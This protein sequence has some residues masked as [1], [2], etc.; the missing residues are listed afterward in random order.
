MKAAEDDTMLKRCRQ[1]ERRLEEVT[2][3]CAHMIKRKD[4]ELGEKNSIIQ[5]LQRKLADDSKRFQDFADVW[6]SRVQVKEKG[7]NKAIAEL[8]FAEGQIVEERKRTQIQIEK[9]K[10]RDRDIARLK[11]EHSE[12]LRVR[13]RY[14]QELAAAVEELEVKLEEQ[15]EVHLGVREK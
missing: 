7:Y 4:L 1:Y 11:A 9:V 6:D 8:A 12:E 15:Y 13:E 5:R 14:R 2:N 10:A 3:D